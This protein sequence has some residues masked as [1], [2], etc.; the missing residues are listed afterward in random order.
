MQNLNDPR[1]DALDL[2]SLRLLGL[3]LETLSVTRSAERLGVSQPTA[4]RGLARLRAALG[5][6]LL[7]RAR[8]GYAL[9]PRA[10]RLRPLVAD[11]SAALER[12]FAPARFDPATSAVRFRVA[13]SD[14]GALTVLAPALARLSLRAPFVRLDVAPIEPD[15]LRQLEQGALDLLMWTD[16][17]LPADFY[18]RRLVV[19]GYAALVR[20]GHPLLYTAMESRTEELA[21]FPQVVP[22]VQ[23][24][25]GWVE[26]DALSR[27]GVP[28]A[29]VAIRTPSYASAPWL[30]SG[31][32]RVLVAPRRL[33]ALFAERAPDLCALPL[34]ESVATVE[35]RLV[36]HARCHADPAHILLRGVLREGA[37]AS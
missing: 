3:L 22:M 2:G 25:A 5:D 28:E 26:D 34:D 9:T 4:S 14:H 19:E 32:D 29:P 16:D 18:A 17:H 31:S 8:G 11:A 24:P 36:W 20:E 10:E 27:L 7:V 30:V 15:A 13:T 12:V 33:A 23:G 6:E 21:R 37:G 1:L 35:L